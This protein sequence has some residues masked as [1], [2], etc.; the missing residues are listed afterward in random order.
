M[1]EIL[2]TLLVVGIAASQGHDLA[3]CGAVLWL[4]I[5]AV[6]VVQAR[7]HADLFSVGVAAGRVLATGLA[8]SLV[9]VVF[10]VDAPTRIA[11]MVVAVV[12]S[13]GLAVR[14]VLRR[15]VLLR[16]LGVDVARAVLVVGD[17]ESV[18]QT[19]KGWAGLDHISIVGACLL[20]PDTNVRHV[21]G[22]PVLGRIEQVGDLARQLEIAEVVLHC[23]ADHTGWWLTQL[24]WSLEGCDV[25]LSLVTPLTD[26]SVHRV[27]L[28]K[29][30]RRMVMT[31]APSRPT[32]LVAAVKTMVEGCVALGLLVAAT[33]LLLACM[34]AIRLDSSGP[35]L[36][37][38]TRVRE[39]GHLFSMFKL[40]TM[41]LD[42]D[43]T[44]FALV[45]RNEAD[46]PLFKIKS[47]DPRV[48]RIG[49]VLRQLSLDELPQLVNVIRGEMSL[50]GPRPA[51]P[52]EVEKY[53]GDAVRRLAVK[54]G[55]TGL[56]QISGRSNLSYADM[57]RLDI[58]YV[59]N[60]TPG[61]DAKILLGTARAVITRD[62]AY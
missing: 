17:A 54:P 38:Q 51:L 45:D 60:W 61:R 3:V 52:G 59:D 48:T 15:K 62:G 16:W 46:G 11:L 1:T 12:G 14:L 37:R 28:H 4:V 34:I 6:A 44:K 29:V 21:A 33:P 31:V 56:W 50:V 8:V 32:G 13:V 35:A 22:V 25:M 49:R 41:C 43:A 9:G 10:N 2:A 57:V 5:D 20:E 36:L 26:T 58:D 42:A 24:Q 40:R 7:L 23:G 39:G 19:I 18:A 47:G 53:D 30:G 55:L 27:R